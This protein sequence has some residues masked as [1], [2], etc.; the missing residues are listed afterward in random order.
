MSG[1]GAGPALRPMRWWDIA[2]AAELERVL[3]TVDPWTEAGFWSELAGV[4]D[5]RYYVVAEDGG[6][7]GR[8]RGA[9]RRRR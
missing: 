8:L 9:A 5:T 1:T 7:S 2:A 6:A 3:F 4:P